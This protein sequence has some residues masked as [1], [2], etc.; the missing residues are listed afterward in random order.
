MA[1]ALEIGKLGAPEP[2][3]NVGAVV[4]HTGVLMALGWHE[5]A[6]RAHAEIVALSA[7]RGRARGATL[8]VT[9]E[10]CN[11]HGRTP[12]CVDA[13]LE[14]GIRRVVVACRDPNPTV[15]GGGL[16]RLRREGVDVTLG[17]CEEEGRR[18]VAPWI[19]ALPFPRPSIRELGR[20]G[21]KRDALS[22]T[23]TSSRR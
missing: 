9:L 13:I 1:T 18:L 12:P 14:A 5:R 4:V 16:E 19:A 11:H 23:R 7:A 21:P 6:G 17:V 22:C 15:A 20:R 2:N 3:P 10:P 8:Y